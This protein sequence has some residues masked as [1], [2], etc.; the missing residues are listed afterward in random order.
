M[1]PVHIHVHN[2]ATRDAGFDESK[3]PRAEDGKFGSGGTSSS[4]S[5][6]NS[7]SS[8]PKA[9]AGEVH[10]K[11]AKDK[12]GRTIYKLFDK[13]GEAGAAASKAEANRWWA[14]HGGKKAEAAYDKGESGL[15]T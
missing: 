1:K 13:N 12:Q 5:D 4:A 3:H 15:R 6:K 8:A 14:D 10:F 2:H 11:E 7:G 9:K